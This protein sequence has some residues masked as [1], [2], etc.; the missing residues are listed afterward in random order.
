VEDF[1]DFTG[2][3][4]RSSSGQNKKRRGRSESP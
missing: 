1:L 3:P 4:H 2:R